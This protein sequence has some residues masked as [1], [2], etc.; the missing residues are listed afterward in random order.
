MVDSTC[1]RLPSTS[2]PGA[3]CVDKRIMMHYSTVG[4]VAATFIAGCSANS[5]NGTAQACECRLVG[6]YYEDSRNFCPSRFSSDTIEAYL[7][8]FGEGSKRDSAESALS[9][10]EQF[11]VNY[12]AF[13]AIRQ[14]IGVTPHGL[15]GLLF[16]VGCIEQSLDLYHSA[17]MRGS[18]ILWGQKG[19]TDHIIGNYEESERAFNEALRLESDYFATRPVQDRIAEAA[20]TR[21]SLSP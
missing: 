12:D 1:F 17:D 16:L 10:E 20:R 2:V 13:W 9:W 11:A 18:A 6:K 5:T 15:A 19:I 8:A 14:T 4:L 21:Q 7:V 3:K